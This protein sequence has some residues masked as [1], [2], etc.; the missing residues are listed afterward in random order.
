[1]LQILK[2]SLSV[3]CVLAVS[4][5]SGCSMAPLKARVD[6]MEN[7]LKD[8]H[9]ATQRLEQRLDDMQIQLALLKRKLAQG[10]TLGG[11]SDRISKLGVVKLQP[12]QES[13]KPPSYRISK[14]EKRRWKLHQVKVKVDEKSIDP[15]SVTERLSVDHDAARRPL[16]GQGIYVEKESDTLAASSMEVE[17]DDG[18]VELKAF[19]EAFSLYRNNQFAKAADALEDF[20]RRYPYH[21][22]ASSGLYYAG[23]SRMMIGQFKE[24]A[25]IFKKLVE[26]YPKDER[27]AKA[28]LLAGRCEERL[29]KAKAAKGTYLELVDTFPLSQE[30]VTANKRLQSIR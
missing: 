16:D 28:L 17:Q 11:T 12:A 8:Q 26:S 10:N 23:K 20:S 22:M 15:Y 24:A 4:A 14:P 7:E 13:Q 1:M 21:D 30:A 5:G 6:I 19:D 29:G 9:T 18:A 27:N 25:S 3:V 2:S